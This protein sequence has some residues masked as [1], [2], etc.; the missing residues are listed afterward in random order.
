MIYEYDADS[1]CDRL[2]CPECGYTKIIFDRSE[3]YDSE[4][5]PTCK[6]NWSRELTQLGIKH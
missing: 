5:C 6:K 3:I 2:R 1:D 4:E